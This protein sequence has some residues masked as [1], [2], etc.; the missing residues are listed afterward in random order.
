MKMENYEF[1]KIKDYDVEYYN[2]THTYLVNGIEVPSITQII[3]KLPEFKNMYKNVSRETL[4]KASSKGTA[5]HLAIQEYCE[6]FKES[7]IPEL[8]GFKTLQRIYKFDV[9][10]NEKPLLLFDNE[11]NP[12]ACGRMD[13][14]IE[15]EDKLREGQEY[16]TQ[17]LAIADLK[18]MSSLNKEYLT[19]QLN[20]YRKAYEQDTGNKVKKL[21]G[22]RLKNADYQM[23]PIKK[24]KIDL[25]YIKKLI[26]GD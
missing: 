10:E 5:M 14:L 12:I 18:R 23:V 4:N 15:I 3:H 8:Q 1:W 11:G 13:L 9:L 21:F 25:D 19:W 26:E 6:W 20:L 17:D 22:I 24:V 16:P 7:Y 2:D